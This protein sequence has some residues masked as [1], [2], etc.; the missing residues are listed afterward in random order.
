MEDSTSYIEDSIVHTEVVIAH[1]APA[2]ICTAVA[3]AHTDD[4]KSNADDETAH[5][6]A[7]KVPTEVSVD[8]IIPAQP[9]RCLKK[10]PY[11]LQQPT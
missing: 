1:I 10:P 6:E 11:R 8:H 4:V 9:T 5:T 2:K 7:S 3:T